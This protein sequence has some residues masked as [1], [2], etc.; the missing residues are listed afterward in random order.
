MGHARQLE[1]LAEEGEIGM[2]IF[3]EKQKESK[4]VAYPLA[5][6]PTRRRKLKV[7]RRLPSEPPRQEGGNLNR[8]NPQAIIREGV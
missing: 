4:G 2:K 6:L 7:I 5:L 3:E 8:K 1:G